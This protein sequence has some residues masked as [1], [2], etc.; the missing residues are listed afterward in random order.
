[1]CRAVY[2]YRISFRYRKQCR[3][4]YLIIVVQAGQRFYNT[5]LIIRNII[6]YTYKQLDTSERNI[7]HGTLIKYNIILI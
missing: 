5:L 7:N 4:I 2:I 6:I 1:M 3:V